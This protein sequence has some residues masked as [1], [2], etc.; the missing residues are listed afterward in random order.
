MIYVHVHHITD[1]V[2]AKRKAVSA[3]TQGEVPFTTN[4]SPINEMWVVVICERIR[5]DNLDLMLCAD[6]GTEPADFILSSPDKLVFVHVKCGGAQHRPESSAGALA[7][8]GGQAIKNLEILTTMRRDL[9]PGNWSIMSSHWPKPASVPALHERIRLV[10]GKRFTNV[11]QA[12]E[13]RENKLVDIWNMIADRRA[14]P[15]VSK[16]IWMIVLETHF[17][18]ITSKLSFAEDALPPANRCRRSN[19]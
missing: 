10:D 9:K 15:A 14:S 2:G 19:S 8:V 3:S 16:E 12:E 17:P 11:G 7:E 6:M 18:E 5:A 13:V 1:R 4:D